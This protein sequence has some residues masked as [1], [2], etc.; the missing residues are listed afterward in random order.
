[1]SRDP[2]RDAGQRRPEQSDRG[3]RR[4][5]RVHRALPR[6]RLPPVAPPR[7]EARMNG[8]MLSPSRGWMLAPSEW[9]SP[10]PA[11]APTMMVG[12]TIPMPSMPLVDFSDGDPI[13]AKTVALRVTADSASSAADMQAYGAISTHTDY[14]AAAKAIDA[15]IALWSNEIMEAYKAGAL[16]SSVS[17]PL[18]VQN[19]SAQFQGEGGA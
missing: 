11:Y 7:A 9:L 8:W 2:H 18:H 19:V 5:R 15:A 13:F 3:R 6:D 1:R 16:T 10:V 4:R 12:A 14:S 17:S